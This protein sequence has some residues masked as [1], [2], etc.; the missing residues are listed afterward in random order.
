M[1]FRLIVFILSVSIF[2]SHV[3]IRILT[4]KTQEFKIMYTHLFGQDVADNL[5]LAFHSIF[6]R[7]GTVDKFEIKNVYY[8]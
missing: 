7:D 6:V 4:F 3:S 2:M 8:F 5:K 1:D